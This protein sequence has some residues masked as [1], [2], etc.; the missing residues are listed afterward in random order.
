M[1]GF[2]DDQPEAVAC[3]P[4]SIWDI[5]PGERGGDLWC[6]GGSCGETHT[7][8]PPPPPPPPPHTHAPPP[9]ITEQPAGDVTVHAIIA[10]AAAVANPTARSALLSASGGLF[11]PGSVCDGASTNGSVD[12]HIDL[13]RE[14][15]HGSGSRLPVHAHV[16]GAEE[17]APL[18][19]QIATSCTYPQTTSQLFNATGVLR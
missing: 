9:S 12:A 16:A 13:D 5:V 6:E 2:Y 10:A 18:I 15:A 7:A 19:V 14:H 11:A 4:Q 1:T 17:N 8:P 3:D